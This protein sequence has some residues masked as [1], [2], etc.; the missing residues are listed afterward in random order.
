MKL[1]L[2]TFGIRLLASIK[3]QGNLISRILTPH[4]RQAIRPHGETLT[5]ELDL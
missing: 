1:I 4:Y 3:L 5:N 2:K